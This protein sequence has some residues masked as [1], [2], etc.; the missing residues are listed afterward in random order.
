MGH[1]DE[2]FVEMVMTCMTCQ[3]L[4]CDE[5]ILIPLLIHSFTLPTLALAPSTLANPS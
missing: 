4:A 2:P 3:T 5:D 1:D